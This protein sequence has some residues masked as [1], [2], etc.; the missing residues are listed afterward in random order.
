MRYIV[1]VNNND[2]ELISRLTIKKRFKLN[3]NTNSDTPYAPKFYYTQAVAADARARDNTTWSAKIRACHNVLHN[4]TNYNIICQELY[5]TKPRVFDKIINQWYDDM[6][7]R[8][9]EFREAFDFERKRHIRNHRLSHGL[10]WNE[11]EI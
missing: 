11:E 4:Q 1:I 7:R 2:D 10:T 6:M 9:P 8:F 5:Q 3:P